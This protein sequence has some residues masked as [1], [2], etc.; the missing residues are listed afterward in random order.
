MSETSS[1]VQ[2]FLF[3]FWI[4]TWVLFQ[5]NQL[6]SMF[7]RIILFYIPDGYLPYKVVSPIRVLHALDE[8]GNSITNKLQMFLNKNWD[9]EGCPNT[10]NVDIEQFAKILKISIVWISYILE[11]DVKPE[12]IEIL[13]RKTERREIFKDLIKKIVIDISGKIIVYLTDCKNNE[14]LDEPLVFG[15][16]NFTKY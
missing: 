1:R 5:I 9:R 7:F 13:E 14:L 12:Y 10:G 6:I 11:S 4:W 16:V 2:I 15:Q 8:K 3:V